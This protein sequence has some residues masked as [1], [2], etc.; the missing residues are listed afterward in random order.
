MTL[1]ME[2]TKKTVE[3]TV[4]EIMRL[5]AKHGAKFIMIEYDENREPVGIKFMLIYKEAPIPYQLPARKTP[6]FCH[7]NGK[8]PVKNREKYAAQDIEKASAVVWRQLFKW[9]QAQFAI[10]GFG[11][12]EVH[13][14]LLPYAASDEGGTFYEAIKARNFKALLAEK[15]GDRPE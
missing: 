10:I 3:A 2:T 6:V 11:M 4:E 5:L 8:K 1:Y 9:L 7:L 15:T 13:E 14:V 12:V